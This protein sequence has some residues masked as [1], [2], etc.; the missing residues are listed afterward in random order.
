MTLPS[1]LQEITQTLRSRIEKANSSNC[2]H[3]PKIAWDHVQALRTY[4]NSQVAI[5][6]PCVEVLT[7]CRIYKHELKASGDAGLIDHTA[8][9]NAKQLALATINHL[10][11][12]LRGAQPSE[13]AQILRLPWRSRNDERDDPS[14]IGHLLG[15]SSAIRLFVIADYQSSQRWDSNTHPARQ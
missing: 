1:A 13:A 2:E 15:L 11:E 14:E 3:L 8:I 7:A 12:A 6:E 4:V 9:E 5:N 10:E